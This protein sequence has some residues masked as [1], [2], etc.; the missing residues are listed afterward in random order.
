VSALSRLACG[1]GLTALLSCT[2]FSCFGL[3]ACDAADAADQVSLILNYIPTAD[4]SPYYFARDTG[5][6]K[7][8]GID[9]SIEVGKGSAFA[10]ESVAAGSTLFGIADLPTAFVADGRGA[11]LVAV[12]NIYA[13]SP[14]G[15]YWLKSSGIKGPK[16]FPGHT[17]GNPPGDA[18]RVMWPAFAK[19]VGIDPGSVHFVNIAPQAKIPSLRTHAVDIITDFYNEH[20]LKMHEFGDDL[21]FLSWRSV[22]I[23][24]Y[25]NS[26]VATR[27]TVDGK[28]DL[29][30]RFVQVTQQAFA[31]CVT[32]FT[33]CLDALL[34]DASGLNREVQQNQWNRIKE[35]MRTPDAQ[36][37]GLGWFDPKRIQSDYTLVADYITL[38]KPFDPNTAFTNAFIDPSI[39]MPKQ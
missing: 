24:L 27:A 16:D 6:Y 26:I 15:F 9:L 32:N 14:Q 37:H 3:V 29:V 38:Q 35:L 4:H 34:A 22:G 39:M 30:K 25:G 21:G 36:A 12:M 5:L 28:P 8:A 11:G 20:D 23:N 2:A 19:A 1:V 7:K 31:T 33:P 17:I 10:A 13:N 18:A